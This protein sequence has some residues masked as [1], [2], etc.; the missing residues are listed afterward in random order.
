MGRRILVLNATKIFR[1]GNPTNRILLAIEDDTDRQ[2]SE[3]ELRALNAELESF[4]YS[5][6][7]DLRAP[8]RAMQGFGEI[9]TEDYGER[10]DEKGRDFLS[11]ISTAAARMN[12]MIGDLLDYS[13]LAREQIDIVP[14]DL[15]EVVASAQQQ[16]AED[17]AARGAEIVITS[18]LPKVLGHS[19]TLVQVVA[20]LLTN[21]AKF[22]VPGAQP[23]IQIGADRREQM[24][25]FWIKDN[26]IGIAP[27]YHQRIFRVFERLHGQ[28]SYPGTGVGL[29][30]VAKAAERMGGR[31]GVES[32]L[33][34]GSCFW[35]EMHL[36]DPHLV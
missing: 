4:A 25:R 35:I 11:R 29:A 24:V 20:N 5:V 13:R 19:A 26:G 14:V 22:V 28:E 27:E 8:L 23:R 21:A 9:L 18:P 12:E 17:L 31:A 2:A 6:A 10:L 3:A 1:P 7:H 30:I 36:A 15:A 33:G 16:L 32:A 34:A